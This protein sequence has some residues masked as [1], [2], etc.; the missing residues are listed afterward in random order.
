VSRAF[1]TTFARFHQFLGPDGAP[2]VTYLDPG[3]PTPGPST[4]V[5]ELRRIYRVVRH[6][7]HHRKLLL[8]AEAGSIQP[9]V[10]AAAVLGLLPRSKRPKIAIMGDMWQPN[11]GLRGRIDRLMIRLADRAID[12]YIVYSSEAL[13]AFPDTWGLD[14][15]KCRYVLYFYSFGDEELGRAISAAEGEH[16][17]AGGNAHRD[18]EPLVEAARSFPDQTFIL[19]TNRLDGHRNLPDNVIAGP[20]SHDHFV[21]LMARSKMVVIPVRRDLTRSNSQQTYLNAMMMGKP[22]IISE[23]FG[24]RDHATP[25]ESIVIVDGSAGGY[26]DAIASLLDERNQSRTAELIVAGRRAAAGFSRRH[27][28]RSVIDLMAD[29]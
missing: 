21:D 17:F 3:Y 7:R 12:R 16:I 11:P 15:A 10:V 19:A 26:V 14:R 27:H 20:V 6:G 1:A 8:N 25:G 24:V 29:L 5:E 4:L 18:Y 9:D 2:E 13:T 22:V 28:A 23:V